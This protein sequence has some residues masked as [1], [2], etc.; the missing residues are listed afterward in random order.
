MFNVERDFLKVEIQVYKDLFMEI[1]SCEFEFFEVSRV[2]VNFQ[3]I[4]VFKD[5]ELFEF[6]DEME[7]LFFRYV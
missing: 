6:Y 7:E 1:F 4:F 5:K 3:E 2:V